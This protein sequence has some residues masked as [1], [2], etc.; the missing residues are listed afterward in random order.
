MRR[1]KDKYYLLG[2]H[3]VYLYRSDIWKLCSLAVLFLL[4]VDDITAFSDTEHEGVEKW[5]KRRYQH[6]IVESR[7]FYWPLA[8]LRC[9]LTDSDNP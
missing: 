3:H 2:K 5:V 8:S 9:H 4:R 1:E 7:D 6:G